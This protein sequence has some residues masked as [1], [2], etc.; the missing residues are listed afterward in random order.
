MGLLSSKTVEPEATL[1]ERLKAAAA[2]RY[3]AE[4]QE[5]N[6]AL[7][8]R[9]A[10]DAADARAAQ[11]VYEASAIQKAFTILDEAGVTV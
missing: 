5:N 6:A 1:N 8:H 11:A 7:R 2:K 3:A 4:Q 10:A 9:E